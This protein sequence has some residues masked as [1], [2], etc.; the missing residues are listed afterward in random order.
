MTKLFYSKLA[1]SNIRKH[2][3]IYL[4]YILTCIF[5]VAM[6]YMMLFIRLNDGLARMPGAQ[7]LRV[8][9]MLGTIVIGIFSAIILLYTNSFLMKRRKKEIGLYNVLGMEKRHIARVMLLET[10]YTALCTIIGGLLTG[11][12]L[13]KLMLMLLFKLLTFAIPF[14]FEVSPVAIVI[15]AALFTGIFFATLLLNLGRV[16]LSKPIELLYGGNVGEKEPK[17]KWPLAI[18]GFAAL[19]SAYTIAIV[20]QDPINALGWFFIA[21]LLVILGTYCLFIA[22]SIALLKALRN[23]KKY[24]YQTKHFASVS[25]MIYRMKQNAAGLAS[26]C[27]LSTMV[28]IMF[29]TTVSLYLGMED[30]LRRRYPR[31]IEIKAYV[32]AR[33]DSTTLERAIDTAIHEAGVPTQDLVRYRYAL[34]TLLL[35]GS[36]LRANGEDIGGAETINA[37]FLPLDDYN[38]INNSM[39]SLAPNEL[40]I[41][42]PNDDYTASSVSFSGIRYEVK[43]SLDEL[44]VADNSS[45]K[46]HRTIFFIL[47]D[48]ASIEACVNAVDGGGIVWG[49]LVYYYGFDLG[50]DTI[51]G[52]ETAD[53]LSTELSDITDENGEELYVYVTSVDTDRSS[54]LSVY[55]GLFF[56]GLFL[57]ALFIMATVIIMYYK[58]ISEGYDDKKRFEIM[59]KVGLSRHEIR[60]TIRSQVLIVFFLPLVFAG[61]HILAAFKMITKLLFMLNLTNVPLFAWCTLGTLILFAAVYGVVYTLT[62]R[63]Y[64]QIVSG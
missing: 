35:D 30:T 2:T 9:M 5:T 28:L 10:V 1:L 44:N 21:V 24:Y 7:S 22:G 34:L 59:Q 26:I 53:A 58:Q 47:P 6:F 52:S 4:P 54:F 60:T 25:G 32:M 8:I 17:T 39:T 57:G 20:T 45:N 61:I 63:A 14:G 19:L 27:I 62:A 48:E 42:A 46:S 56:L 55:G 64:Y 37:Y 23:N 3:K 31:D 41:Y 50:S 40:L 15:T 33:T 18:I 38:N 16:H 49:G 36:S 12:L 11:I 13:S 51:S 29:S 43:A